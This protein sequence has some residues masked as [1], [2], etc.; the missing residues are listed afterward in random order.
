VAGGLVA[1]AA[2]A[3]FVSAGKTDVIRA[4]VRDDLPA[5]SNDL[6]LA[7]TQNSPLLLA[8]P[9]NPRFVVLA[10]RLDAPTFGCGLQVSGDGGR[11]YVPAEPVPELP[12][13]A[14]K[15]YSPEVAFDGNGTLYYLFVGLHGRGNTPMGIFLTTSSDR[16]RTFT[17]PIK[18]LD[19][20]NYQTRMVIDPTVDDQGRIHL[21]WLHTTADPP[22]G[23]LP[24][25]P[26]PILTAYSDDGGKTFSEPLEITD[27]E[28]PR[29]VAPAVALGADGALHVVYYDLQGDARD[30][31]GLRGPTWTGTWSVVV[32]SSSDRRRRFSPAVVVSDDVV[33]PER[34][35]LIYTM[36]PPAIA[37]DEDDLYVAWHDARNDDWDVFLSRSSDAGQSWSAP[38]RVNDDEIRNGRHQYLPDLS[39]APDGRVDVIFYDRRRDPENVRNDVYYAYSDDGGR[40]FSENLRL[41]SESSDSR[42]GQ[43]YLVPSGQGRG[44]VGSRISVLAH[45]DAAVAAWGDSRNVLLAPY[46]D[47]FA[48]EIVLSRERGAGGAWSKV[49]VLAAATAVCAATVLVWRRR[50][51]S[52]SR[53]A[54]EST[55]VPRDTAELGT[56]E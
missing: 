18:V 47:V 39:V 26:N 19:A 1:A 36:P 15:C 38:T 10:H 55:E 2:I 40:T 32:K 29:A 25:P 52:R 34:V 13:G 51:L 45:E 44:D 28:R 53:S 54:G 27:P 30:Y 41:T 6:R 31:Q 42:T 24:P 21:V 33:P 16:A 50:R 37:A 11:T 14:E 22:T 7:R 49:G 9:T 56:Q 20:G 46:S 43:R 12:E 17:K 4:Q 23:G 8:D 3:V 48:T 35:L 5:T